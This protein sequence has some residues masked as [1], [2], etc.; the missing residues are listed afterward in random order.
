MSKPNVSTAKVPLK[1]CVWV[2]GDEPTN[3]QRL[4]IQWELA[5]ADLPLYLDPFGPRA[6]HKTLITHVQ[7]QLPGR[8]VER[9]YWYG[10]K[11]DERTLHP[12]SGPN[13]L[14]RN[15]FDC[16]QQALSR[17]R[18]S[19]G[20]G[21]S[22][23]IQV[24]M[25]PAPVG[26]PPVD[27]AALARG[28]SAAGGSVS[29]GRPASAP[30]RVGGGKAVAI[31]EPAA[32]EMAAAGAGSSTLTATQQIANPDAAPPRAASAS[33]SSSGGGAGGSGGAPA[34]APTWNSTALQSKLR[35]AEASLPTSLIDAVP[36]TDFSVPMLAKL[37]GAGA[38]SVLPTDSGRPL[39]R[40]QVA[41]VLLLWARRCIVRQQTR[42]KLTEQFRRVS[43]TWRRLKVVMAG[44]NPT[45][46]DPAFVAAA[47]QTF[48]RVVGPFGGEFGGGVSPNGLVLDPRYKLT[49]RFKLWPVQLAKG[50]YL[51][52]PRV[53][54]A[55]FLPRAWGGT[56]WAVPGACEEG[57][58]KT[59]GLTSGQ[60]IKMALSTNA[61]ADAARKARMAKLGEADDG[62]APNYGPERP[63]PVPSII[64]AV[65]SGA[66]N[67]SEKGTGLH[68][69][70]V[71]PD[72]LLHAEN[73]RNQLRG[74]V[75]AMRSENDDGPPPPPLVIGECDQLE[76]MRWS[77][78]KALGEPLQMAWGLA[79]A[80]SL[81]ALWTKLNL[82]AAESGGGGGSGGGSA[83]GGVGGGAS[84]HG[85]PDL[86]GVW[87]PPKARA[88]ARRPG[89]AD[90]RAFLNMLLSQKRI[91]MTEI[92]GG[93][94]FC[95]TGA[96]NAAE[97]DSRNGVSESL[98]F[99]HAMIV[100]N[101]LKRGPEAQ[102]RWV[103]LLTAQL[104][105]ETDE[106]VN[107]LV[108]ADKLRSAEVKISTLEELLIEIM[109]ER[110]DAAAALHMHT[111]NAYQA[112]PLKEQ[113]LG[114]LSATPLGDLLEQRFEQL[115]LPNYT[116]KFL[117]CIGVPPFQNT[118]PPSKEKTSHLPYTI[119]AGA[120]AAPMALDNVQLNAWLAMLP[121]LLRTAAP[122]KMKGVLPVGDPAAYDEKLDAMLRATLGL[123][124]PAAEGEVEDQSMIAPAP[125]SS[126]NDEELPPEPDPSAPPPMADPA[127]A[128]IPRLNP[129]KSDAE[130]VGVAPP[131]NANF[132]PS[133]QSMLCFAALGRYA[134]AAMRKGSDSQGKKKEHERLQQGAESGGDG[135][136]LKKAQLAQIDATLGVI[137]DRT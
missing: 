29:G 24:L 135:K 51:R 68:P 14:T 95:C 128:P 19:V 57:V 82:S 42:T 49:K 62:S 121:A 102:A 52:P 40:T 22:S 25:E 3:E 96:K 111:F 105:E 28:S 64:A 76:G 34:S 129:P 69:R 127:S 125:I 63:F 6:L 71:G 65:R 118:P 27:I 1:L 119:P 43:K 75:L 46:Y 109:A 133:I 45:K 33:G 48:D 79:V 30:K 70:T 131:G 101:A 123:K 41:A 72:G 77:A 80:E 5:V 20:A 81:H 8:K 9:I 107:A 17:P 97:L 124:P 122:I 59:E 90:A 53:F 87:C 18:E 91:H 74:I 32:G 83:T 108:V 88:P 16:L 110:S 38:E 39:S 36:D 85:L 92:R 130:A 117:G 61:K 93:Y 23:D 84:R 99:K 37:L 136:F 86:P 55:A 134:W 4:T 120:A 78:C 116:P 73:L 50:R 26:T 13:D 89:R 103:T 54:D 114:R 66:R 104:A 44:R 58:P 35:A 12:S 126:L 15:L 94:A 115:E 106:Q 113:L 11:M 67:V 112:V 137:I 132:S 56:A 10:E 21:G 2:P 31:A 100:L 60:L 47:S 7:Q 98:L